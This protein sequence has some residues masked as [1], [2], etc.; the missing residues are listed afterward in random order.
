M[1]KLFNGLKWFFVP[2]I[3]IGM[4]FVNTFPHML[5]QTDFGM[6][7]GDRVMDHIR[8]L[9]DPAMTGRLTGTIGNE[10]AMAY[11][12]DAF[13]DYGLLPV[14]KEID[15]KQSFQTIV[16]EFQQEGYLEVTLESDGAKR[17]YLYHDY[18]MYTYGPAGGAS[19]SGDM[20]YVGSY[21]FKM[22]QEQLKD[23]LVVMSIAD[24]SQDI[25]DYL[26]DSQ[27][28]GALIYFDSVWGMDSSERHTLKSV[29]VYEKNGPTLP[30]A[31]ISN[32]LLRLLREEARKNPIDVDATYA[33]GSVF[34]VLKNAHWENGIDFPLKETANLM[35][36]IKGK[37][38]E[39]VILTA[40][41][42][43]VGEGGKGEYFPGALDNASGLALMLEMARLCSLQSRPPDKTLLFI[44]FNGEEVGLKGS[45][46]YVDHPLVP[47]EK[48]QVIN[49]DMLGGFN[50]KALEIVGI[51][52]NDLL[53][54]SRYAQYAEN[55]GY[56]VVVGRGGGSDH[57]TFSQAGVPSVMFVQG[58]DHYHKMS[59]TAANVSP[60]IIDENA[61]VLITLL[62]KDIYGNMTMDF[63]TDYERG[64]ILIFLIGLLII[65]SVEVTGK[66]QQLPLEWSS[67]IESF[68]YSSAY[69]LLKRIYGVLTPIL[70]LMLLLGVLTQL[71]KDLN[72]VQ[73]EEHTISNFS[74]YLTLKKT[75]V[76][77]R[78]LLT[79]GFGKTFRGSMVIDIIMKAF[80]NSGKLLLTSLAFAIPL[81]IFKGFFDAYG[82]RSKG[83]L[84][85]FGSILLLSIPDL[86]WILLAFFLTVQIGQQDFEV[87]W[88]Q[89]AFLRG[90]LMPLITLSILPVVYVSRI[91][92][93]AV[94]AELS[95]PYIRALR[96]KGLSKG[97][98]FFKHLTRP[99]LIKI[100]ESLAGLTTIM[101]SNLILIEY[102]F[103]YK[104]IV[105]NILIYSRNDDIHTFI[106][107]V[108]SLGLLFI[109]C[110]G[111]FKGS[112][113]LLNPRKR[114]VQS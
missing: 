26:L 8:Q 54:A 51:S 7:D 49:L 18:R 86:M 38:D 99:V 72:L 35:G 17:F 89:G 39:V 25:M 61:A 84:R 44:A 37:S 50:A 70:L 33:A 4:I 88:L 19:F 65:Y 109:L 29:S 113:Y 87:H 85:A 9:S 80:K 21:L 41:L 60:T 103:D 73:L 57:E 3:I 45:H 77:Y 52:A 11:V 1:K 66:N 92:L 32:D 30:M 58:Q 112:S 64:L 28:A 63:L 114:E 55:L 71:P 23:R 83:E 16:P 47:L 34:G 102:L 96:A 81:G 98:L 6:Y 75:V 74:P 15:Y 22:P 43:H 56:E 104:G 110:L 91:A 12:R 111:G 31:A 78:D 36:M 68:Y 27:A 62:D 42:D 93:V 94:E 106:G 76:Y 10:A 59:D 82:G 14:S 2:A 5:V 105:N 53:L 100:F 24:M 108:L 48:S 40:H 90:W 97:S 13:F 107:L 101:I 95:K 67:R 69:Q 79:N 20:I 46:Y